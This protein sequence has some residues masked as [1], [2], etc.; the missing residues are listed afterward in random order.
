[1]S[2]TPKKWKKFTVPF[3][4]K[5]QPKCRKIYFLKIIEKLKVTKVLTGWNDKITGTLVHEGN[6][7]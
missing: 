5:G 4:E 3:V 6:F 2:K 7:F 1:M